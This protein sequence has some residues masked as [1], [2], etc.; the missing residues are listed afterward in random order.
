MSTA[1]QLERTR[2]RNAV[3][4]LAC[5]RRKAKCDR[6][7]PCLACVGRGIPTH[8]CIYDKA[9]FVLLPNREQRQ[10]EEIMNLQSE[11][12][13]LEERL[14]RHRR[15]AHERR[16]ELRARVDALRRKEREAAAPAAAPQPQLEYERLFN[17]SISLNGL[18][19]MQETGNRFTYYGPT[20]WNACMMC[21]PLLRGLGEH[22]AHLF[23]RHEGPLA[24]QDKVP[25]FTLPSSTGLDDLVSSSTQGA[26]QYVKVL[27]LS[28]PPL[29][30]LQRYIN[31]YFKCISPFFP[32]LEEEQTQR[33]FRA[34]FQEPPKP[35]RW[36]VDAQPLGPLI[37]ITIRNKYLDFAKMALML[38]LV[39]VTH[40]FEKTGNG[41]L[42]LGGI[43]ALT[44]PDLL[45]LEPAW[46]GDV[47]LQC[48]AHAK[49]MEKL[50]PEALFTLLLLR[51]YKH[52]NPSDGDAMYVQNG[53]ILFRLAVLMGYT[54]GMHRNP[55]GV[56]RPFPQYE[57]TWRLM[58][59]LDACN[60][61]ECG[62]IPT[63]EPR[64]FAEL[65]PPKAP[66]G[67]HH[68][69]TYRITLIFHDLLA[70][71]NLLAQPSTTTLKTLESKTRRLEQIYNEL[72]SGHVEDRQCGDVLMAL[73]EPK[74]FV[75]GWW[76]HAKVKL[77]DMM[78]A[79]F[80]ILLLLTEQRHYTHHLVKYLVLAFHCVHHYAE[81]LEAFTLPTYIYPVFV[82][83]L[84]RADLAL[85]LIAL[86]PHYYTVHTY[87]TVREA[88]AGA[89]LE[90]FDLARLELLLYPYYSDIAWNAL[91]K[92]N[93]T[94]ADWQLSQPVVLFPKRKLLEFSKKVLD[95]CVNTALM[96]YFGVLTLQRILSHF[97]QF[98]DT[99]R[100]DN[101]QDVDQPAAGLPQ[102]AALQL[103]PM[104][105]LLLTLL[106]TTLPTSMSSEDPRA[107]FGLFFAAQ[108]DQLDV[109]LAETLDVDKFWSSF[110]GYTN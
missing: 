10:E 99:L 43:E 56:E 79:M 86:N 63:I 74:P 5:R 25:P 7:H 62:T 77:L 95:A 26:A 50:L 83:V 33:R 27:E 41:P 61:L 46:L 64:C 70:L 90:A 24:R 28:L 57:A 47:I 54:M 98:I 84:T 106:N 96:L 85:G 80:Y 82:K 53:N 52:F 88:A 32:I 60:S 76:L 105:A 6:E 69:L 51:L 49:Y 68:M 35:P 31:G 103:L 93:P 100:S 94:A 40:G 91:K 30:T 39:L 16:R 20:L 101:W 45:L 3:L 66:E 81:R 109:E 11:V 8:L 48:L 67:S 89:D 108:L 87:Q 22:F 97:I 14:N 78:I 18:L 13:V 17:T 104:P 9:L 1:D 36:A 34:L 75:L 92:P 42:D 12:A 15:D 38:S 59:L 23:P 29:A 2:A 21:D 72:F 107:Y 19:C 71:V 65:E 37:K 4:C 110:S 55:T 73:G 44:P 58:M 102:Q